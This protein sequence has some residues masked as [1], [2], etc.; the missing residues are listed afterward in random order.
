MSETRGVFLLSA[1]HAEGLRALSREPDV[2]VVAAISIA[3]SPGEVADYIAEATNAQEDGRSY[4]FVLTEGAKVSG[5]CR[6]IGV[7]GVPRL[8]VAIGHA[9]RGQGN[10]SF[11]VKH[12]LQFAFENLELDRV[13]ATG[14]CLRLVSQFGL[15]SDG[16]SLSRQDWQEAR[17]KAP[18][19]A[20]V[21]QRAP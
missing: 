18:P 4:V 1:E 16:H 11:L 21:P 2:A 14:A 15:L 19:P 9:Y 6:L 8:I 7:R 10:G 13:T 12:V 20:V 3:P 17:A 5:L